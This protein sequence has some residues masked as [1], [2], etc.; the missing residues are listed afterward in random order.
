MLALV[1]ALALTACV[2][3]NPVPTTPT[4][5]PI[6]TEAPTDP[7]VTEPTTAPNLDTEYMVLD[8]EDAILV[9]KGAPLIDAD[10]TVSANFYFENHYDFD[11]ELV[12]TDIVLNGTSIDIWERNPVNATI[13]KGSNTNITFTTVNTNIP[14]VETIKFTIR[15]YNDNAEPLNRVLVNT[16]IDLNLMA[17]G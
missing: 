16:T 6:V 4:T 17:V 10:G 12:I 15:I 14:Q 7:I 11:I 13:A 8:S 9:L 5:E 3:P 2:N 1:C